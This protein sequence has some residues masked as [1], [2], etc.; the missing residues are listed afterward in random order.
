MPAFEPYPFS[1][2]TCEADATAFRRARSMSAFHPA[3]VTTIDVFR[4]DVKKLQQ[5]SLDERIAAPLSR[6]LWAPCQSL[7]LREQ[8]LELPRLGLTPGPRLD[9][10]LPPGAS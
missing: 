5:N 4:Y 2:A 8:Q 3:T 1:F 9:P 10:S 7:S 6:W